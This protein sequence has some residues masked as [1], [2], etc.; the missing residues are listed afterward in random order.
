MDASENRLAARLAA[1]E[2]EA[3]ATVYDRHGRDLYGYLLARTRR[4]HLAEDLLQAVMLRLVR[5]RERLATVR[6]FRAYLFQVARNEWIRRGARTHPEPETEAL[7]DAAAPVAEHGGDVD[8]LRSA[9]E[10][11]SAERR[12]VV[13]LK[14]HH[15]L[16]FAQIAEVLDVLPDTAASRYRRALADLRRLMETTDVDIRP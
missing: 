11:L 9:L 6:N 8:A 5:S 10:R 4:A 15:G 14:I 2:A 7:V 3:F 16:T 12:E 13:S 1:G